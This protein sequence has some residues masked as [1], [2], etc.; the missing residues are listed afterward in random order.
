MNEGSW[1]EAI[2]TEQYRNIE[3]TG[4]PHHIMLNQSDRYCRMENES[5][6]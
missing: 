3:D 4:N 5:T 1:A 2:C 6:F